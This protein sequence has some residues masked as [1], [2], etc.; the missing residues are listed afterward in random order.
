M[1]IKITLLMLFIPFIYGNLFA[2]NSQ[3]KNII[4]M[5][6]DGMGRNQALAAS[7]YL[8][9]K[10]SGLVFQT[11][12]KQFYMST[13]PGKANVKGKYTLGYN[14]NYAN[15]DF[16]YLKVGY[17]D[18][19]PA[20]TALSTGTKSYDG[21]I[22]LDLDSNKLEHITAVAKKNGR[23]AGVVT[24][25]QFSHATPAGF[26][27]HNVNRNNY[28]EIAQEMIKTDINVIIGAGHPLYDNDGKLVD[29]ADYQYVGGKDYLN[30][31][32]S[33]NWQYIDK[34]EDFEKLQS[35]DI[36]NKLIGVLPVHQTA[37]IGRSGKSK[38]EPYEV[39]LNNTVPNLA[40]T[41]NVALNVLNN[42]PNGFFL[43]VEGGAI[44][45]ACH[46]N[47]LGRMIEEIAD[48]NDAVKSV[49]DWIEK[50]SNWDETLLVVTGDHETGYITGP[51]RDDNNLQTNPIINN[52]KGKLPKVRWNSENHS[53]SLVP[54][55]I[56][57]ND[58]NYFKLFADE[59]DIL[60]G[61][62]IN[63]TEMS[64]IFRFLIE[65]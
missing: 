23:F 31:I 20:A 17:T 41:T 56:K 28:S 5:I 32:K 60:K 57:G 42:N 24:T 19:A 15:S 22:G 38:V 3:V 13:Y 59:V 49:V 21:A 36:S 45:W 52:G 9:G 48:F 61:K 14:S 62:F 50:N 8:Y 25:V 18:S 1:K 64:I 65:N 4:L 39:P 53:N 30:L 40:T 37:N 29:S 26:V 11:F 43:M 51:T 46:D 27:A 12:P 63:N 16:E 35:G 58:R 6:G 2:H 47:D 44:D 10:D 55:Y 34:K 33:N 7:Y 54:V